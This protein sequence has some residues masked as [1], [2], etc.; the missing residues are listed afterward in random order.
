MPPLPIIS[1]DEFIRA[2]A[3]VEI[4]TIV[5]LIGDRIA[6]GSDVPVNARAPIGAS[7]RIS[8]FATPGDGDV[9]SSLPDTVIAFATSR[10]APPD[11]GPPGAPD[12]DR[13]AAPGDP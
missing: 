2:V 13:Q 9:A 3:V 6:E 5:G 7:T 11:P 8:P 10:M 4:G 1:G 12:V